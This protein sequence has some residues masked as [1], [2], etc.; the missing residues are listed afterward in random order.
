MTCCGGG[1]AVPAAPLSFCAAS[2]GL[3]NLSARFLIRAF[4]FGGVG[5]GDPAALA[6]PTV[7]TPGEAA[8]TPAAPALR[9]P[10]PA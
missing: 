10:A 5:E 1:A 6:P 3:P 9:R 8:T 7:G 2:E 4:F